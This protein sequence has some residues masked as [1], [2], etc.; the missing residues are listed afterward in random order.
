M[1]YDALPHVPLNAIQP[2]DLLFFF[3]PISHVA[4]YIGGGMMIHTTH[5]GPGGEARI[6]AL[7]SIWTP[8]LV[9]AARPG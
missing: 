7:G 3:S 8:L 6:E 9:G 2:G 5:P 1:Q 4:L